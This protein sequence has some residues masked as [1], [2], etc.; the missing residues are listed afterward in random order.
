MKIWVNVAGKNMLWP[1]LKNWE[2]ELIFCH[3]AKMIFLTG[4]S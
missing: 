3:A 1:Y 2:L 4:R